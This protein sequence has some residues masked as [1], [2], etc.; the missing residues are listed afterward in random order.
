MNRVQA[1]ATTT[2]TRAGTRA[3]P[4]YKALKLSIKNIIHKLPLMTPEVTFNYFEGQNYIAY[5]ASL[6]TMSMHS[7]NQVNRCSG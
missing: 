2:T 5:D 7:K 3:G 6:Y 4:N 1:T